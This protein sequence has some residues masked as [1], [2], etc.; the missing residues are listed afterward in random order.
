MSSSDL[1]EAHFRL[2]AP[3]QPIQTALTNAGL[4]AW[5]E[6]PS[7]QPAKGSSTT[8][9]NVDPNHMESLPRLGTH[10]NSPHFR[11]HNAFL[12]RGMLYIANRPASP[13]AEVREALMGFCVGNTRTPG[14]AH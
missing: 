14:L 2:P 11:I 4:Q 8:P 12:G 5:I 1:R 3:K 10:L 13:I 7:P 9:T 6:H